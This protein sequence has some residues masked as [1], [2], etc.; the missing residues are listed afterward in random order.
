MPIEPIVIKAIG[1]KPGRVGSTIEYEA[2]RGDAWFHIDDVPEGFSVNVYQNPDMQH[3]TVLACDTWNDVNKVVVD[4]NPASREVEDG[5]GDA[6]G[7]MV[8]SAG[9]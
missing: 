7:H 5:Y 3:L 8:D 1:K 4:F 9:V 2:D 6:N